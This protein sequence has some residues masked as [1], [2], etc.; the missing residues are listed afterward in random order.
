MGSEILTRVPGGE[1]DDFSKPGSGLAKLGS[2]GAGST[3][4]QHSLIVRH[5]ISLVSEAW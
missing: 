2:K 5:G 4:K 1:P 3:G